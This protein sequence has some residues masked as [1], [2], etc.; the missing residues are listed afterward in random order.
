MGEGVCVS[1]LLIWVFV[2]H[3]KYVL[4]ISDLTDL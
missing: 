1:G 2:Q 3:H 4:V